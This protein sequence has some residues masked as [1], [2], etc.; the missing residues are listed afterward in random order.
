M[1]R[2]FAGAIGKCFALGL[3][4]VFNFM[5]NPVI[6]EPK[7]LTEQEVRSAVQTW[8]RYVTADA[9]PDAVIRKM[10]AF[11]K[12]GKRV[13]FVAYLSRGGFC[14]CGADDLV[15][16]VYW[17]SPEGVYD[18]ENRHYQYILW[19]IATRVENLSRGLKERTSVLQKF[20]SAFSNRRSFW[21][22]LIS[23]HVPKGLEDLV[24]QTGEP[25]M[26][27]LG[28]TSLWH[29]GSP[30]N[31]QC[32][33]LTPPDERTVVGC[34]ATAAVQIM[35]Y[36]KWPNTGVGSGSVNYNF[37]WRNNWDEEPLSADPGIPANWGGGGRLE[38]TAADG[39]RLRMNGYWDGGIFNTAL[40]I[41]PDPGYHT[42]LANLW[43]SMTQTTTT[44][45]ANF[46]AS[47]YN[48]S[49]IQNGHSDPV[50]AGD[51]EVAKICSHVGIASGMDY[52][53][54][55]SGCALYNVQTAIVDHFRYDP[56]DT[57]G[58][59]DINAMTE[60]ILWFRP[61]EFSGCDAPYSCHIFVAY[62]YNKGT[63]PDRQFK[64][65][66][67]HGGGDDGWFSLDSLVYDLHQKHL[68]Q[69][70][71]RDVVRFV[72]AP[73]AGDGSPD[74]PYEDIDEALAS[75]P[76]GT[77]LVFKAGSTNTF[78]AGSLVIDR[79][80]TLKGYNVTVQ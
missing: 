45:S 24:E 50:D 44:C 58:D 67:G 26:M 17:Y 27:E 79:P 18:P 34:G 74:N 69:I 31:D 66:M 49:I 25:V 47:T 15:L 38:W 64:M 8:V 1:E 6:A 11:G 40:N 39:G 29:Q 35:Y 55:D 46:G 23:G 62:G 60:E 10:E 80:I 76:D 37:R 14:L 77:T 48:W 2:I 43:G 41:S 75:V 68:T 4:L 54:W 16:P 53:V 22:G 7:E 57:Y 30:Y 61:L 71:P 9:R 78:S 28:L 21:Q 70:A 56:D 52:G 12:K 36:W 59:A 51:S 72:G 63:D 73:H 32:P 33:M 19:R 13:G 3:F 42:A 5:L 20:E 65:N